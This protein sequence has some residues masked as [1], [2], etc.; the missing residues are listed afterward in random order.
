MLVLWLAFNNMR[1]QQKLLC[2]FLCYKRPNSQK[3]KMS[4]ANEVLVNQ[5][6]VSFEMRKYASFAEM[7]MIL[8][9]ITKAQLLLFDSW[10]MRYPP[11]KFLKSYL[12]KN[13]TLIK[14]LSFRI[15]RFSLS[16]VVFLFLWLFNLYDLRDNSCSFQTK[17][18]IQILTMMLI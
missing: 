14:T 4:K 3:K 10:N 17:W 12:F 6:L 7:N 2:L 5:V 8:M 13:F 18:S 16:C 11:S 1:P 15:N 9:T